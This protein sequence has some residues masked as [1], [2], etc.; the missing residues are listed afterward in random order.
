MFFGV[1]RAL[2]GDIDGDDARFERGGPI[3]ARAPARS[4]A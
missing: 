3:R 2:G 4:N 1:A